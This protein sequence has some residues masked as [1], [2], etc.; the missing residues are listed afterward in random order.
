[1]TLVAKN[2]SFGG[3]ATGSNPPKAENERLYRFS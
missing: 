1:M 3:F 2:A